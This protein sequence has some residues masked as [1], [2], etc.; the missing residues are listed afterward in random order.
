MSRRRNSVPLLSFGRY[1]ILTLV[2]AML[3]NLLLIMKLYTHLIKV[4]AV[5]YASFAKYSK[6]KRYMQW[7]VSK[8]SENWNSFMDEI[9]IT[10]LLTSTL[11][12]IIFKEPKTPEMLRN[13]SLGPALQNNDS[14]RYGI[15]VCPNYACFFV[16]QCNIAPCFTRMQ[17]TRI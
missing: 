14:C 9:P 2:P 1:L 17:T 7:V 13:S 4:T 12:M 6:L 8:G 5:K 3:G 15:R 16:R 10:Y 11:L